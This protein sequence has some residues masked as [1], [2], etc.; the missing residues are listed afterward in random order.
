[1]DVSAIQ[2]TTGTV[3]KIITSN[4]RVVHRVRKRDREEISWDA[5]P[6]EIDNHA[7]THCFGCNF[8]V[9]HFTTQQ[10]TVAPFLSEYP[11]QMD[12]PICSA[13]TA[14]QLESGETVIL[15]FG[16]GL[17]FGNR[18]ERSLINPNQCRAF[19]IK[20]C[21]DPTD[22]HRSLGIEADANSFI[23]M[24]MT[25]STC[26]FLSRCPTDEELEEC[27]YI[28]L[29]DEEV[30]DPSQDVFHICAMEEEQHGNF[31]MSRS[32]RQISMHPSL[33]PITETRTDVHF[34]EF[35]RLIS[36]VNLNLTNH[37]QESITKQAKVKAAYSEKRHSGVSAEELSRMWGIGLS[38]AKATL[39]ATTQENVRSA[40]LPLTRRY[41]TDLMSQKLK[42]LRAKFYTD[43]LFMDETSTKGN[44]CAQLY[45]DGDGFVHVYP[46]QSKKQAGESLHQFV[47]DV[48][49]MNELC[50]DNAPEQTGAN[51]EFVKATRKY[52]IKTST[53]EPHSPWQNKAEGQI[54]IVKGRALRRA[55]RR[56]VPKRLWDY[57]L[58]Y[59][60]QIYSRTAGTDGR[61]GMERLT[62]DTPDISDWIDFE[63][64]DLVW[65]RFNQDDKAPKIGRWLGVANAI[66]SALNY[67]ILT[68]NGNIISRTTVQ[69]PTATEVQ[70]PEVQTMIRQFHE[71]VHRRLGEDDIIDYNDVNVFI[72][73]DEPG[74]PAQGDDGT[75]YGIPGIE[76]ADD[77]VR[78]ANEDE[79][80]STYDQYIGVEVQLPD[81]KGV[82]RMA[83]VR[84]RIRDENNNPEDGGSYKPWADHST[85]E[86][87]FADGTTSVLTANIIA[88]NMLSQVDTEGHHF[89]LLQEIV[90]HRSDGR[91]IKKSNG[92][93][94]SKSGSRK[95]K[96]TTVGWKLQVEWKDGSMSWV[97]LKDLKESNPLELAEYAVANRIDDEPAFNWWVKSALKT[98]DRIIAK[99]ER[100][101]IGAKKAKNKYWRT[102]HK[103]GIEIPK[104][105]DEAL[106]IDR[107]TGTD[108]WEKAIRKE[109]TNVRIAFEELKGVTPEQMRTGK[110]KPGY[111]FCSTHMIFDIKMDGKFTRKARLVAD[112]HKTEAPSS[113]TYSSVVSRDS[114]RIAFMI[115]ALNDLD[116]CACDIGNAYLNANCREKLWTIAGAEFG[117]EDKGKVMIIA[118]ALYGLKSSGAAWRAKLAET[119]D[120]LGYKPTQS[121]PDVWLK[122]AVKP[123]GDEYYKY[124]L[125]YVDDVLHLA[126]DPLEDMKRLNQVYR[127]KEGFGPPD[128]YLG[129]NV[130]KV[131]LKNGKECWSMHSGDYLKGAI[132]GIDD[133]LQSEY[134]RCLKQYGKGSRPFPQSYHPELDVT[135][136]LDSDGI[137]KYQQLIGTLR[138]AIELGRIDIYTEVSCLS[139]YLCSPREGH[140][141]A[142]YQIFRYLQVSLNKGRVGRLVFDG[143]MEESP[144]EAFSWINE[145][146]KKEWLDFYPDAEELRPRNAPE[147]LGNDIVIR[148][149]VDANH[150][151]NLKNRR[152]HT[153]LIIY[154]NNSP[155]MWFSKRQNTVESSSFGS[156]FVALRIATELIE[157]LRYKLRTFGVRVESPTEIYCDNKSVVQN[158]SVPESTLSKRHNA[159]CYHRVREA[160]AA[161]IIKVGWIEG[162]RNLADL[163]TKTTLAINTRDAIVSKIFDN[164]ATK[165][166]D[167]K[168]SEVK[169]S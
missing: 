83:R 94:I 162:I 127:L 13:G 110:V 86:V 56:R 100:R 24:R 136:E 65:Y 111:S 131:Q 6:S 121:D 34:G 166:I 169:K 69:H 75:Y 12:I 64:Y 102:T 137:S 153:G 10:C 19:G 108:Y 155:I 158:S 14:Y 32:I 31:N 99:L 146:T 74:D 91:A 165:V 72:Y 78:G 98:R 143:T 1:M 67:W 96:I 30:W 44:T 124:M 167:E 157:A 122:K 8:R 45:A 9:L 105:V 134:N 120:S 141:D 40:I 89:Q 15:M 57:G 29:S 126:H 130:E 133:E 52:R 113:L 149:Y 152:S 107:K 93:H 95:P 159:I 76:E 116:V 26:G 119:L 150:A 17:W 21:D 109:M 82:N 16:Q 84:K 58:V 139:Q 87:E 5:A 138:W 66:G 129:A 23:P 161:E 51:S 42:R 135:R 148:V 115:A 20:I 55:A 145:T 154:V 128:R 37:L 168:E 39:E 2:A 41:R 104:T 103:F 50:S 164:N 54:R 114:V 81:N 48:G 147:P 80:S 18:M 92:Y 106:E 112:G 125:V 118:R 101:N 62:G 4:R 73:D 22:E 144:K 49:I 142:L 36:S 53:I 156:E 77:I 33:P 43:T 38:K 68:H 61:T 3:C 70:K 71:E 88:Q 123:N 79:E 117:P 46:M 151:G 163:F 90:D 140:L 85:Y 60:A 47:N 28:L 160:Q 63:F 25:G 59:E 132:K 97:D 7:D 11:E 35:D 27:R